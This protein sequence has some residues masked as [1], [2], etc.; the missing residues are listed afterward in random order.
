MFRK[1]V[2]LLLI[3]MIPAGLFAFTTSKENFTWAE[4][5]QSLPGGSVAFEIEVVNNT[6]FW[7]SPPNDTDEEADIFRMANTSAQQ[8][9]GDL[10]LQT[11]DSA[12]FKFEISRT[13]LYLNGE[14][15]SSSMDYVLRFRDGSNEYH[16]VEEG[17]TTEISY[18]K[19]N[20]GNMKKSVGSF[21][22][23]VDVSN[24]PKPGLYISTISVAMTVE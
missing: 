6:S 17:E 22:A 13:K 20:S 2:T 15:N 24:A 7:I 18:V 23:K 14:T 11:K 10:I 8:E 16:E 3:I 1:L 5:M 12:N 9:V 21:L 4:R 19:G